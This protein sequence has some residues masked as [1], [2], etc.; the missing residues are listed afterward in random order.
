MMIGLKKWVGNEYRTHRERDKGTKG[1][2]EWKD[3]GEG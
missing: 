3:R 2:K 1:I